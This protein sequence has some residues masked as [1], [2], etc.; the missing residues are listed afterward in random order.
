MANVSHSN[1]E[2]QSPC[3]LKDVDG[4]VDESS[5]GDVAESTNYIRRAAG[6]LG[7]VQDESGRDRKPILRVALVQ[8][9]GSA[10]VTRTVAG[11]ELSHHGD[12]V[13]NITVFS[14]VQEVPHPGQGFL[15]GLDSRGRVRIISSPNKLSQTIPK[16]ESTAALN[17]RIRQWRGQGIRQQ[18]VAAEQRFND[19]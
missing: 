8:V 15:S 14:S 9:L 6:N 10:S 18:I 3:T 19:A 17:V 7:L 11:G 4:G 16:I 12:G 2:N 13:E 5:G 1:D